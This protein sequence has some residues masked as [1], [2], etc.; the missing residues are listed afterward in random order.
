MHVPLDQDTEDNGINIKDEILRY[1]KFWKWFVLA[2][3]IG[4]LVA[5]L[6]LRFTPETY[7]S[8]SKIKILDESSDLELSTGKS[9]GLFS[10]TKNLDNEIQV[11]RS[12]R[13]LSKVVDSLDLHIRY[14][15]EGKFKQQE[16]WNP[17]FK[18][19]SVLPKESVKWG[20]Y[21]VEVLQDGF[22]I[23][24]GDAIE[25]EFITKGYNVNNPQ[26]D[27]PFIITS[28]P[29]IKRYVNFFF[30]VDVQPISAAAASL[31]NQIGITRVGATDILQL[32][33][34]GESRERSEAVLNKV[35]EQFN[36]DGVEDR[37]LVFQRTIDF[38]DERFVFLA[39]ELDSIE[40]DKKEFQQN[41]NMVSFGA[42]VG[43]SMT[44]KASTESAVFD[45][46]NQIA[47]SKLLIN[48]LAEDN[49]GTLLPQSIGLDN[50]SANGLIDS[51]NTVV[52][53]REAL[54]TSAGDN[55]PKVI[56][57]NEHLEELRSNLNK[58]LSTYQRQLDVSLSR[59]KQEESNAVGLFKSMPQK[60]K[61]LRSIERQQNLKE[62]LYLL[63]LQKREE[64][65]INLAITAPSIK[66]VEY[67]A[68]S[69][70]PVSPDRNG[71]YI[72]SLLGALIIPFGVIFLL[73]KLDTKIHDKSDVT[74]ATKSIPIAGEI[75][76]LIGEQDKLFTNPHDRTML[77]ESFRI[78]STNLNYV[79]PAKNQNDKAQVI[80]V[81]SSI[82]GEGKTFV[83]VNLALAYSSISKRV[84]LIGADLR[85]PKIK[86][87][88]QQKHVKGL[89]DVLYNNLDW[90]TVLQDSE[91]NKQYLDVLIAGTIPPNPAELLSNGK[92]KAIIE[93][94]KDEYDY[95]IIDTAPVVPVT[96]TLLIS[97]YADATIYVVRAGYTEK[98]LLGF[99]KEIYSH[100]KLNNMVYVVNDISEAKSSRGYGYNYGYGYGYNNDSTI[101]KYTWTWFKEGIKNKLRN[102]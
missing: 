42:D 21:Y 82:K 70:R 91:Y 58:S 56:A 29:S 10:E 5:F 26:K 11:I 23:R 32:N 33:L 94:A 98:K 18:F 45:I 7:K 57:L 20:T 43:Y 64:A 63:L 68:S 30:R 88:G 19:V 13:L 67:A 6:Y 24:R 53:E 102:L 28:S 79:L 41:N 78:L 38:V 96:D 77:A 85:N 3:I 49:L 31:S 17:P 81:T 36:L 47:L 93:D 48:T 72:K 34:V 52:L 16:A 8:F 9:G 80:Y 2:A 4:V 74:K 37:Q 95:I 69:G 90:R 75:P 76:K 51:Y 60:E 54:I 15:F 22:K 84:L 35:M 71:I 50:A 55:N 39:E 14:Y 59:L 101:K 61:I 65:A 25:T 44:K 87:T 46:E 83:S 62:N 86:V 66:I 27:F 89:S 92:L 97:Q 99:S 100:K 73:F 40:V 1:L 12:K